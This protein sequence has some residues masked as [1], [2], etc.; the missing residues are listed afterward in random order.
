MHPVNQLFAQLHVS[1]DAMNTALGRIIEH[2]AFGR[3]VGSDEIGGINIT[4]DDNNIGAIR[5]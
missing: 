4:N 5:Q 3:T 1:F 2:P